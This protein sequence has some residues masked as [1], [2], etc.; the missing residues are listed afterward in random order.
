MSRDIIVGEVYH[1]FKGHDVKVLHIATHTETQERMVIYED[2]NSKE[3]WV[4]PY[5][6]FNSLVDM[7]KYPDVKQKYRFELKKI[8]GGNKNG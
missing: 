4:R 1:H 5:D 7:D 3:V 6:M 2:I 8:K